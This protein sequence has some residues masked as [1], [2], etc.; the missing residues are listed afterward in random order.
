MPNPEQDLATHIGTD[1]AAATLATNCFH[2]PVRPVEDG[3]PAQSVYCFEMG[4]PPADPFNGE[5]TRLVRAHV[6]VRVRSAK[7][8]YGGSTGKGWADAIYASTEHAAISGYVNVRNLE[9]SPMH[10]GQDNGGRHEWSWTV[11]MMYEG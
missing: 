10:I 1:V 5:S 4:G 7:D 6:K 11:E 8:K 3:Y 9:G 2:G